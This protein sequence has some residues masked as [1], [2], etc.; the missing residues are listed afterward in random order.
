MFF[1]FEH[2]GMKGKDFFRVNE[3]NNQPFPAHLHR[4]YELIYIVEGRLILQVEK[5]QY[6]MTKG[7]LAFIFCNQIHHFSVADECRI[8]VVLFAPEIIGGFY[9]DHRDCIP[10][11]NVIH[12]ENEPDFF[13]CKSI[14]AQKSL[15]YHIC[16]EL[17]KT[18]G[19]EL[20]NSNSQ[21]VLLQQIF[22][23]VDTHY[24]T[25]CSLKAISRAV[26][27]DYAYLSKLFTRM[28]EMRFTDYLNNYRIAQ[29]CNLLK[30]QQ[31]S[32][33][34]VAERCGYENLRTFHRNFRMIMGCSPKEYLHLD[35]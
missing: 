35:S 33:S 15:L 13:N 28:T 32:V 22:A 12:L 19:M 21:T 16:D 17:V 25:E 30:E 29:A 4:A 18:T 31:M 1:F 6:I 11:N 24:S 3:M 10:E 14:Y 8:H 34:E 7:D 27:Y 5:K 23:Y 9:A 26:Q 20:A 2:H